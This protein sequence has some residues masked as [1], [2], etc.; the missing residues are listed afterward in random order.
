[1]N[2]R[3]VGEADGLVAP[4]GVG[5]R[6]LIV[7]CLRTRHSPELL[8]EVGSLAKKVT[9]WRPFLGAA[10]RERL[11][12]ILYSILAGRD[13]VPLSVETS[14]RSAYFSTAGRNALFLDSLE[15]LLQRL[16]SR[17]VPAIV[18]KGAALGQAVYCNPALRPLGD[19]DLLIHARHAG[20]LV[21]AAEESGFQHLITGVPSL[22]PIEM[23][24]E[25]QLLHSGSLPIQ[26]DVHNTL[27][28]DI[29]YRESDLETWWWDTAA[30]LRIG[31][32]KA[33]MLGPEAQLLHLCTHLI[34]G[35]RGAGLLWWQD[36]A[37]VVH[38]FAGCMDW[39]QLLARAAEARRVL[40]L[41][42]V[43]PLL[44]G[45]LGA[46][47][48]SAWLDELEAIPASV[49]EA[50]LLASR[51]S[52]GASAARRVWVGVRALPGIVDKVRYARPFVFPP[53]A[54]LI[55]RYRPL[56]GSS[57]PWPLYYFRHWYRG[58]HGRRHS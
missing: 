16:G 48:P 34:L 13:L 18:L 53:R 26:L 37:E 29:F 56:G 58:L 42:S 12:P 20:L 15:G 7:A 52:A 6:E 10:A 31:N 46:P 40:P 27:W 43:M 5:E 47:V 51:S 3:E 24:S 19:L 55:A 39:R 8:P 25:F 22:L 14:L 32:A 49:E 28:G 17:G 11:K 9:D 30:E 1:M 45:Q 23:R 33:E 41:K 35:H 36:A 54:Y 38:R 44:A 21:S 2:L 4:T 50:E 57:T